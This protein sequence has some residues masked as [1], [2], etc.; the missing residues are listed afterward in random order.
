MMMPWE[1]SRWNGAGRLQRTR[2]AY[3]RH[4]HD[5]AHRLTGSTRDGIRVPH[6][7]HGRLDD[8]SCRIPSREELAQLMDP[9]TKPLSP[10]G[11]DDIERAFVAASKSFLNPSSPRVALLEPERIRMCDKWVLPFLVFDELDKM[12]FCS[13]LKGNVCLKWSDLP[14]SISGSTSRAGLRNP[15]IT[16]EL[17]E[18]LLS[19]GGVLTALLHQMIHAYFLQ[20]CGYWTGE[21]DSTGYNLGH[22]PEFLALKVMISLIFLRIPQEKIWSALNNWNPLDNIRPSGR[23]RISATFAESKSGC[24]SCYRSD[25]LLGKKEQSRLKFWMDYAITSFSEKPT[26]TIS[27]VDKKYME[28]SSQ[29]YKGYGSPNSLCETLVPKLIILS[30]SD[31][32]KFHIIKQ[33]DSEASAAPSTYNNLK[34][35]DYIELHFDKRIFPLQRKYTNDLQDLS[36]SPFF[37]NE[38][39]LHFPSTFGWPEFR[40]LYSFLV[41]KEFDPTLASIHA[42][43]LSKDY[44]P[45]PPVILPKK[46]GSAQYLSTSIAAAQLGATLSFKPL[47][48]HTLHRLNNLGWT[49]NN[50]VD[51]LGK[52][53]HGSSSPNSDLRAWV[54][55]WLAIKV[56]TSPDAAY[57]KSYPTNLAVLKNHTNW[58]N[59]F[60]LLR[61]KEK[62]KKKE[63]NADIEAVEKQVAEAATKAASEAAVKDAA[64]KDAKIKE[65]A[66][67]EAAGKSGTG[68]CGRHEHALPY[69]HW[70]PRHNWN[71]DPVHPPTDPCL[72]PGMNH[73]LMNGYPNWPFSGNYGNSLHGANT[74]CACGICRG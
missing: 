71:C 49:T 62:D 35:D 58:K 34:L 56:P 7:A 69:P 6:L 42:D 66:K 64:I 40:S 54:K 29:A 5:L 39:E 1:S 24:S 22:G 41:Y 57:A 43:S 37:T 14:W 23:F 70:D 21:A 19:N 44:K 74:R 51:A 52:I 31:G 47:I 67:K 8:L 9:N 48:T 27:C 26:T 28:Q 36:K 50:P 72:N 17:S 12:L 16:V 4:R 10:A 30:S 46:N 68:G 55:T 32:K 45:S 63:L 38:R 60:A 2:P 13:K 33:G 73:S 20:C 18:R 15:R 61:E 53:Y 65:D 25:R 59:E 11:H 3:S